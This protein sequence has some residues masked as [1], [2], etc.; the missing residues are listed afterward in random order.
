MV[1]L[2]S[3][4][5]CFTVALPWN[6]ALLRNTDTRRVPC[7]PKW[8]CSV[9]IAVTG[10]THFWVIQILFRVF[11]E[12]F[13]AELAMDALSIMLAVITNASRGVTACLQTN[14]ATL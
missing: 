5:M 4:N 13:H 9:Q 6:L 8:D 1:A 3:C 10:K 12:A 7:V 11:V 2:T 14:S